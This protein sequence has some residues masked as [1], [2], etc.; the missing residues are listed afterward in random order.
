MFTWP[1]WT[2]HDVAVVGFYEQSAITVIQTVRVVLLEVGIS[3]R[4]A[5]EDA[6]L[7]SGHTIC[8]SLRSG[9]GSSIRQP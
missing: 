4:W 5:K 1:A 8:E 6:N 9:Q 3:I 7:S 2:F